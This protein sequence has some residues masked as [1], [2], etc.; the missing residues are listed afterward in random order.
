MAT[1]V[2][3]GKVVNGISA[4]LLKGQ[5]FY[6][7]TFED[8]RNSFFGISLAAETFLLRYSGKIKMV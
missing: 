3:D 2:A 8:K 5:S 7:K 4:P 1:I 6:I